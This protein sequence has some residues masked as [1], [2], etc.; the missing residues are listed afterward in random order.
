MDV[1]I[2]EDDEKLILEKEQILCDQITKVEKSLGPKPLQTIPLPKALDDFNWISFGNVAI[3]LHQYI[4]DNKMVST[5]FLDVIN[6][7]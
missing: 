3:D 6:Y 4:T 1:F 7:F 2:D 5:L